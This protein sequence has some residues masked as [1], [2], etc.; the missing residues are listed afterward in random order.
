MTA[1]SVDF[2]VS[3]TQVVDGISGLF[4]NMFRPTFL[5]KP[6]IG[7]GDIVFHT[8]GTGFLLVTPD[9]SEG[10]PVTGPGI[11]CSDTSLLLCVC[12]FVHFHLALVHF[13]LTLVHLV[14]HLG[15]AHTCVCMGR[16]C[17][18]CGCPRKVINRIDVTIIH[19]VIF[20]IPVFTHE[21]MTS[22]GEM[23]LGSSATGVGASASGTQIY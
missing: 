6:V 12:F 19:G 4:V 1:Q 16:V 11:L 18:V 15:V 23:V 8:T 22:P 14:G 10:T 13:H 7:T 3:H 2:G 21:Q 5:S 20:D 17:G 9:F